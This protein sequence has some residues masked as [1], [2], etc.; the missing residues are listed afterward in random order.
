MAPYS[1]LCKP[2]T[3][4]SVEHSYHACIGLRACTSIKILSFYPKNCFYITITDCLI[5]TYPIAPPVIITGADTGG[6][7]G[8]NPPFERIISFLGCSNKAVRSRYSNR[9]VAYCTILSPSL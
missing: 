6:F 5:E 2:V 3:D 7:K 9:A 4:V 8:W 1:K